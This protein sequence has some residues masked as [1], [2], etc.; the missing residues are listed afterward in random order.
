MRLD[1]LV[2]HNF[3][4]FR[5]V[6]VEFAD[7]V[8][9][10]V[11]RNGAG[12]ST[13][14]EAIGWCLFGHEAARTGKDLLKRRGAAPSD[15]V[16]VQLAFR[17]GPHHYEVR[18]ELVGKSESHVAEVQ[19]DGKVVV[20][21]G[22][23]SHKEATGYV[24]RLFH[25][26]REAFFTSL[27]A[28]QRE[29]AAL[30][31]APAAARKRILI[32]LLR[33][34]ALDDAI[35][36]ARVRKRTARDELNGLRLA[37]RDVAPM[38]VALAQARANVE[39]GARRIQ[40]AEA[41]IVALVEEVE[42]AREQREAG[43]KLAEEHRMAQT[44]VGVARERVV[45][46]GAERE[47]RGQEL[48]RVREAAVQA[49]LLAPRLAGLDA[50][51]ARCESFTSL[52]V[53]HEELTRVRAEIRKTEAESATAAAEMER[54]EGA[55][56]SRG[57][58]TSLSERVARERPRLENLLH[59]AQKATAELAAR[60]QETARA[61]HDVEQKEA[62]IR[63]MGA[64]SPCPTCTRPLREH[65][66][67][68][69]HGLRDEMDR[70]RAF[71]ADAT[72]RL[73]ALR[74]QEAEARKS[75]QALAEREAE[76]RKKLAHLAREEALLTAARTR[77][78]E[79]AGRR[80]RLHEQETAL[81]AEAYD[82][83]ADEAAR[84]E[85]RELEALRERHA[86]F[87]AEAAREPEVARLLEEATAAEAAARAA[88]AE[89]ER[90]V[91]ALGFDPVAHEVREKAAQAAEAKLT[92]ARLARERLVGERA[93]LA[94]EERRLAAEVAAQEELAAKGKA[95]EARILLLEQLAGDRDHGLLPEFKDHLI[96]RI[97][98][99]LSTHAGRLF[100]DLTEGRYADLE[101]GEDYSLLVHDEGKAYAL[102]RFS[103]GEGDL[104]NLCLR[105]AVSQVVAERAGTEGFGFLALDE[106]FG[107]QDD[108]RK[109][110]I[111]R[112]LQGLS[113]RFRQ[114]LLITH[115][116]DVKESAEHVLRVEALDDG[117][118][119]VTAE[120]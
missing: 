118:S 73:D 101:V 38:R 77:V 25:M 15:D 12:K 104:A 52:R 61:L 44:H 63:A 103:G 9:A 50:A 86:R 5:H 45:H 96:G 10:L 108:V 102:E 69:L 32:G 7:G 97:R 110:N 41:R 92:E 33:L 58:V 74:R 34:D 87:M 65:H 98:P 49:A 90:R 81:S 39:A 8:T 84:K 13:F 23:S 29:L 88:H 109:G 115:I 64:E 19:V 24:T 99:V 79:G 78:A 48:A 85:V 114:I 20:P 51:R 75:V 53:R 107:S 55:L 17:L 70:H 119:R 111:L 91:L 117:T 93:R 30:T 31:D 113:A 105:L 4:R 57:T 14:L 11:G 60:V 89:A 46:A 106:V 62:R 59:D 6:D 40:E 37:M 42:T 26:D 67:G 1:R 72:P 3:R 82:A 18:R 100:R 28:R 116:T 80:A 22:P 21:A 120:G 27:V 76:L 35:A 112:G 71:L 16:R 68:I 95:L 66:G 43:R 94:D 54:A 2:I 56:A 47:R 83:A 36:L